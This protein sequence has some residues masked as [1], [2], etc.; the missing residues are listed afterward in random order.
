MVAMAKASFN[1]VGEYIASS[2]KE[3]IDQAMISRK[4]FARAGRLEGNRQDDIRIQADQRRHSKASSENTKLLAAVDFLMT[5]AGNLLPRSL[6][7]AEKCYEAFKKN[8]PERIG[9]VQFKRASLKAAE[10]FIEQNLP[11]QYKADEYSAATTNHLNALL[12][13]AL[14]KINAVFNNK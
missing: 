14:F 7:E 10:F 2:S 5:Q 6:E 3:Q 4:E 11:D 13:K 9:F 8:Y 12:S 1:S